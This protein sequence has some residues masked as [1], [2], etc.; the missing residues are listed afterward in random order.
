MKRQIEKMLPPMLAERRHEPFD[1]PQWLCEFKYDGVRALV[2]VRRKDIRLFSRSANELTGRFPELAVLAGR[3]DTASAVLDG[4]LVA[5]DEDGS[6]DFWRLMRRV[7]SSQASAKNRAESSPVTLVVFDVLCWGDEDT[8]QKTL[9]RRKQIIKEGVQWG[10]R[11]QYSPGAPGEQST[12]LFTEA[13]LRGFEGIVAKKLDSPYVHGRSPNWFKVK[14]NVRGRFVVGGITAGGQYL[15]V[16]VYLPSGQL[17]YVGRVMVTSTHRQDDDLRRAAKA[18]EAA[19]APFDLM[20]RPPGEGVDWLVPRLVCE[21]KYTEITPAGGLRH[22]ELTGFLPHAKASDCRWSRLPK[23]RAEETSRETK[24]PGDET[25]PRKRGNSAAEQLANLPLHRS[26]SGAGCIEVDGYRV[27]VS[28]PDK[29]LW[30]DPPLTK[31]QI[32]AY[33]YLVR[34]GLLRYIRGRP[35]VLTRYPDGPS[36]SGFYQKRAPDSLPPWVETARLPSSGEPIDYVVCNNAATLMWLINLAAFELHPFPYRSHPEK[37]GV[38]LMLIDLDPEPPAGA[39]EARH[40]ASMVEQLMSSVGVKCWVKSSGATGFHVVVPL[41]PEHDSES[42]SALAQIIGNLL[43]RRRP[44]LFTLQRLKKLR[45]G[46]VYLDYLQNKAGR[47]VVAPYCLRPREPASVSLP[48]P[49]RRV[50]ARQH[51]GCA[52]VTSLK[53]AVRQY[54]RLGDIWSDL[55]ARRYSLADML[56]RLRNTHL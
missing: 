12:G 47:T 26:E 15:L 23:N 10:G 35:L 9:Q 46:K 41:R 1:D 53:Q 14:A 28:N 20:P 56:E 3:T 50:F 6:H 30:E 36:D 54:C 11:L 39:A 18:A 43:L 5:V 52:V 19:S 16:G 27:P 4:E 45:R 24:P 49:W 31:S 37:G 40:A 44:D 34:D 8:R 29:L 38:D 48:A 32:L 51:K 25:E 22:P 17:R 42:V 2:F 55:F 21:V 13:H 7:R 33:Y